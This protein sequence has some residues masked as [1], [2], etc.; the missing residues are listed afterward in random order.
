MNP[1]LRPIHI[2]PMVHQGQPALMLRDPLRLTDHVMV[3]PQQLG[4]VLAMLDGSRDLDELRASLLVRAGMRAT[5]GELQQIVD[6]LDQALL[7][8]N[9]RFLDACET[10]RISQKIAKM[11]P[12]GVVK[13]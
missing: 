8:H 3:V 11:V 12:L 1:R 2:V 6:Q 4:P 10:A 13:G 7:L 5:N 9:Q